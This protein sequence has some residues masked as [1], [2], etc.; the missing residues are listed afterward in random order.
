MQISRN[1]YSSYPCPNNG[2]KFREL[3]PRKQFKVMDTLIENAQRNEDPSGSMSKLSRQLGQRNVA[4]LNIGLIEANDD[5]NKAGAGDSVKEL[6]EAL[7]LGEAKVD[8]VLGAY[9]EELAKETN[10][11]RDNHG[12]GTM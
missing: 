9:A 6:A 2:P 12:G 5:L 11:R 10:P 3:P 8:C 1:S 7:G 4:Y